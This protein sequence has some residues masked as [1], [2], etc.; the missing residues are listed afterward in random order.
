MQSSGWILTDSSEKVWVDQWSVSAS[1][2]GLSGQHFGIEKTTL[3]AGMSQGVD[4]IEVSNG[5]LTFTILPTRGMSI[6]RGSYRGLQLG[7]EAPITGPVHP[8]FVDLLDRSGL[9]WLQGFDEWIVRCG[10]GFNGAPANDVVVDNNGNPCEVFLNLHGRIANL[11]AHFVEVRI[12]LEEPYTVT[13]AGHVNE[14]MLFSPR[15]QLQTQIRTWPNSNRLEIE[16]LVVNRGGT[17]AE[18]ELL[19]HCN[20][21]P[22]FLGAGSRLAAPLEAVYPRDSRA[23]EDVTTFA[24]YGSPAAGF[25]EQVY[26]LEAASDEDGNTLAVLED[27]DGATA[28]AVRFNQRELPSLTL[29]KNTA[30]AEDGYVTGIEPGTDYPNSRPFEREKGRL[31]TLAPGESFRCRVGIEIADT[32]A[33]V[34]RLQDEVVSIRGVPPRISASPHPDLSLAE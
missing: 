34:S 25:V 33:A 11:P 29:W 3:K 15:L 17:P 2:L 21:G 32:Q 19:Y 30:A 5:D 23:A 16:D 13:V 22:P 26:W 9:G 10:L 1:D 7:W 31:A 14:S 28:A 12:E 6:W 20:F 4:A 18:F 27:P 8:Q 24:R